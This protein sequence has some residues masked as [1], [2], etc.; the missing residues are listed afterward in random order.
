MG[1]QII[2]ED[3]PY[4]ERIKYLE[5][6]QAK[7]RAKEEQLINLGESKEVKYRGEQNIV[8]KVN[9][10]IASSA[11]TK[12]DYIITKQIKD[13]RLFI[14][15][16]VLENVINMFPETYKEGLA[17]V[18]ELETVKSE[19][20]IEP[21]L[22]T[23]KMKRIVNHK[24]VINKWLDYKNNFYSRFSFLRSEQHKEKFDDFIK[25]AEVNILDE[26]KLIEESGTK[27]IFF[28]LF[29]KY[30]VSTNDLYKPY[31]QDFYSQLFQ[32]LH[33]KMT[34]DQ[35]ILKESK[36]LVLV[37]REGISEDNPDVRKIEVLYNQNYKPS[38][39]FQYSNYNAEF[40]S[41]IIINETDNLI[42]CAEITFL[43]EIV[44]NL[45]LTI[46]YKLRR[47]Q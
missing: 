27:M 7:I 17:M 11:T 43:E 30:L 15:V 20:V 46:H 45:E 34:V 36:D 14:T 16:Q 38:I 24:E 22:E 19:L 42:E 44:N 8:T 18:N 39:G 35:K 32:P 41:K 10:I 21:D 3:L 31:V 1:K 29:D 33:Y 47:I 25:I 40:Q 5:E 37:S 26:K 2:L 4:E 28:V 13:N 6:R 12:T 9:N 23:G